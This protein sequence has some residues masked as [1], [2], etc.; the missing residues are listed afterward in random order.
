MSAVQCKTKSWFTRWVQSK[1]FRFNCVR[2]RT[3]RPFLI[4]SALPGIGQTQ[5]VTRDERVK[6]SPLLRVELLYPISGIDP[7]TPL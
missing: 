6:L 4:E 7:A 2:T 5:T 3:G 1:Y